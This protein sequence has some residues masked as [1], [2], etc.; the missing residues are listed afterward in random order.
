MFALTTA[1]VFCLE[2]GLFIP[3]TFISSYALANGID[4]AFSFQLLAIL[5]VGS[6]F[7]RWGP[8]FIADRMGRFNTMIITI[9]LCIIFGLAVW[10]PAKGNVAAL[11]IFALGFGF[12]SG[13]NISLTPV[14]VGQLCD[15]EEYG[16]YYATA[17]SVVS[18]G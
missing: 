11:V 12:A 17:Y 2:W 7:G 3:V 14:C 5:N 9:V 18:F 15:T 16:K 10:L 1:G 13:S 8:G 4:P 6:F